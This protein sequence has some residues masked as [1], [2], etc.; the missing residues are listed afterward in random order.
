MPNQPNAPTAEPVTLRRF[1]FHSDLPDVPSDVFTQEDD[2]EWIEYADYAARIAADAETIRL[3][4]DD[5]RENN[6]AMD[7]L[8]ARIK[9][10]EQPPPCGVCGG[11]PLASGRECICGG[12]GTEWDETHGLRVRCF[13][14]EDRIAVFERLARRAKANER[15]ARNALVMGTPVWE[16]ERADIMMELANP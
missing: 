15:A 4:E 2:G 3:L 7:R 10:L 14:L 9:E 12:K 13:E 11:A 1:R 8:G 6:E 5:V 16:C